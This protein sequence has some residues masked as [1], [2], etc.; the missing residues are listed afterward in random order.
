[1]P[2][3]YRTY[4]TDCRLLLP[5]GGINRA[6]LAATLWDE[7]VVAHAL[8]WVAKALVFRNHLLLWTASVRGRYTCRPRPPA[9]PARPPAARAAG[10]RLRQGS[11][12]ALSGL[13]GAQLWPCWVIKLLLPPQVGFELLERTFAHM[14][15]N[16]NECWWDSWLLDVAICNFAGRRVWCRAPLLCSA[17]Q[18]ALTVGPCAA[19]GPPRPAGKLFGRAVRCTCRRRPARAAGSWQ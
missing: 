13:P 17:C 4:A 10:P 12:L 14:L 18:G 15:P 7:F 19:A 16:F 9:S 1:V 5:G 11:R 6:A 2:V 3:D 8:G